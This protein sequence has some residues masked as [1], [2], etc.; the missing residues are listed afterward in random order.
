MSTETANILKN[1]EVIAVDQEPRGLQ[2][3]K[4]AE[5]AEASVRPRSDQRTVMFCAL[6]VRLSRTTARLPVPERTLP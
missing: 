4:V 6:P 5:V 3:V 1:P 2:G